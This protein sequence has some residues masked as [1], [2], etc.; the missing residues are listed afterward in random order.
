MRYKVYDTV[1]QKYIT[2]DPR[3]I[4][5][6]DGRLAVND[7]GDEIGI[8][9]CIVMFYPIDSESYYIDELGGIHDSGCG[10]APDGTNCGECSHMSCKICNVWNNMRKG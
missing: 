6:P 3:L 9:H 5:K 2:D 1:H 10:W 4:L 7:F 8:S